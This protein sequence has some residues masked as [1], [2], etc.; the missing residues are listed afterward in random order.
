[1]FN[2]EKSVHF[3]VRFHGGYDK[4]FNIRF[5]YHIWL[6]AP[7]WSHVN[8]N[9]DNIFYLSKVGFEANIAYGGNE[10]LKNEEKE[11]WIKSIKDENTVN[12]G[13]HLR[14]LYTK[15]QVSEGRGLFC[16]LT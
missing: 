15:S 12:F 16:H 10:T 7:L 2:S 6:I 9:N 5:Q 13:S 8:G 3:R 4:C 11:I 1:M 14:W